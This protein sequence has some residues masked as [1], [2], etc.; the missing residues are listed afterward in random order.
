MLPNT[1][2]EFAVTPLR[3]AGTEEQIAYYMDRVMQGQLGAF[4]LTEAQA[5]SDAA[6]TR[7]TARRDGDDYIINGTK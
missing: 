5:G 2:A 1:T 4:C 6:A 7:T 3:I